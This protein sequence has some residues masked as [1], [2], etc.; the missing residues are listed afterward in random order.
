LRVA[1]NILTISLRC[2]PKRAVMQKKPCG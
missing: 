1:A 2:S